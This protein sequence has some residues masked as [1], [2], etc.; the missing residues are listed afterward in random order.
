[1]HEAVADMPRLPQF[2]VLRNLPCLSWIVRYRRHGNAA[3]RRRLR[4]PT[5]C[6]RLTNRGVGPMVLRPSAHNQPTAHRAAAT[7]SRAIMRA[8]IADIEEIIQHSRKVIDDGAKR[9]V[10]WM[11]YCRPKSL[12]LSPELPGH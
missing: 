12:N 5:F 6:S 1:M 10:A 4:E 3:R 8:T 7:E 11:I 2:W 9:C